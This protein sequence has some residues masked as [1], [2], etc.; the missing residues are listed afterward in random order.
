MSAITAGIKAGALH[1]VRAAPYLARE[2]GV[3]GCSC[4]AGQGP[5]HALAPHKDEAGVA[6]FASLAQSSQDSASLDVCAAMRGHA[7]PP[8]WE[9]DRVP[10]AAW[11]LCRAAGSRIGLRNS[12]NPHPCEQQHVYEGHAC[13][14]PMQGALRVNRFNAWEGYVGSESAGQDILLSGRLAMNRAMDGDIVAVELLPEEQWVR[15]PA[16]IMCAWSTL[17]HL[18]M[19]ARF[20]S[21]HA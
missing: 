18:G 12:M 2:E 10:S 20:L 6:C 21:M 16:S 19:S 15:A 5:L 1:Q 14:F 8:L 7:A 11:M 3:R 17:S 9:S 4:A 13:I